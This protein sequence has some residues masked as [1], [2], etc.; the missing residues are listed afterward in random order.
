MTPFPAPVSGQ[1]I[2]R[3]WFARLVRFVNSLI[4]HGDESYTEVKH[5]Y[6]GTFVTL[7]AAA[8]DALDRATGRPGGS[9]SYIPGTGIDITGNT[10]S[11][12]IAPGSPLPGP[13]KSTISFSNV[14][15]SSTYVT[16]GTAWIYIWASLTALSDSADLDSVY[17]S[18][19]TA[20]VTEEFL[21]VRKSFYL[22]EGTVSGSFSWVVPAGSTVSAHCVYNTTSGAIT[23][24]G[25]IAIFDTVSP[26]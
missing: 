15:H 1:Q 17:L 14:E 18:V 21:V 22:G 6:A 26:T 3:G 12:T 19:T 9:T 2:P 25:E 24:A 23:P 7:T 8:R 20:G 10:I 13:Y 5:T 4:L 16:N 11:C